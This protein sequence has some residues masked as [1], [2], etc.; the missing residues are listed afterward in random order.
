M[1]NSIHFCWKEKTWRFLFQFFQVVLSCPKRRSLCWCFLSLVSA[2]APSIRRWDFF[3]RL[4]LWQKTRELW[5]HRISFKEILDS[6]VAFCFFEVT[7]FFAPFV[8]PTVS[9]HWKIRRKYWYRCLWELVCRIQSTTGNDAKVTKI[10]SVTWS[11]VSNHTIH[12]TILV[13]LSTWKGDFLW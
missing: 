5:R 2:E 8:K 6:N 11:C 1:F 9:V 7:A 13:Y 3:F 12:G 4:E 10:Q